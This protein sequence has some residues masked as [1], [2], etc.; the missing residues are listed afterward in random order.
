MSQANPNGTGSG[1]L[2]EASFVYHDTN[3]PGNE[4]EGMGPNAVGDGV[5][6]V[7][8]P[9]DTFVDEAASE[10]RGETEGAAP[11]DLST[12]AGLVS[13]FQQALRGLDVVVNKRDHN[14][15]RAVVP[16]RAV[17]AP[18]KV[19]SFTLEPGKS[20]VAEM[21]GDFMTAEFE[22]PLEKLHTEQALLYKLLRSIDRTAEGGAAKITAIETALDDLNFA[23]AVDKVSTKIVDST[24]SIIA[25]SSVVPYQADNTSYVP[26]PIFGRDAQVEAR[27]YKQAMAAVGNVRYGK[28]GE[29]RDHLTYLKTILSVC[30]HRYTPAA[31]YDLTLYM[32]QGELFD[33]CQI[34]ARNETAFPQFWSNFQR[35]LTDIQKHAGNRAANELAKLMSTPNEQ[36][37]SFHLVKIFNAISKRWASSDLSVKERSNMVQYEAREKILLYLKAFFPTAYPVLKSE[38]DTI[39]RQPGLDHSTFCNFSVLQALASKIIDNMRPTRQPMCRVNEFEAEEDSADVD[40]ARFDNSGGYNGNRGSNN[41]KGQGRGGMNGSPRGRVISGFEGKCFL[42]GGRDGHSSRSCPKY[43]GDKVADNPCHLCR[44]YHSSE[45]LARSNGIFATEAEKESENTN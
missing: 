9:L 30:N 2:A 42:C 25:H 8:D 27:H 21:L 6:Q 16:T 40:A 14:S 15:T 10:F 34:A 13:L 7:R 19:G 26:C 33:Y 37:L 4:T 23:E 29:N 17:A 5:S 3:L 36:A 35:M 20:T 12:P 1:G 22:N 43:P 18:R 39:L 31:C 41:Q 44:N 38:F 32:F 11:I 28:G 45:C 24:Q